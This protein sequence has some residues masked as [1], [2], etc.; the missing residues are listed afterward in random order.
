MVF[1]R[2]KSDLSLYTTNVQSDFTVIG[3]EFVNL[4]STIMTCRIVKKA[5][6]VKLLEDMTY[7]ELID[8]LSS[9]WRKVD[10]NMPPRSSDGG[11]IHTIGKVKEELE[12]LGLSIPNVSITTE[13]RKRGRPGKNST[14]TSNQMPV[15]E[16]SKEQDASIKTVKSKKLEI[17]NGEIGESKPKRRVGRPRKNPTVPQTTVETEKKRRGRP[18]K[19]QVEDTQ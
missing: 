14:D 9:A 15:K 19:V 16:N 1:K 7:D 5:I 12:L 3:S 18:R 10:S 8:D 13:K 6:G 4:L 2:Y 11:W 17:Q